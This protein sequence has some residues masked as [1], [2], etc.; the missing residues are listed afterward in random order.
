MDEV[1]KQLKHTIMRLCGKIPL[2]EKQDTVGHS[3]CLCLAA[4][5]VDPRFRRLE[6]TDESHTNRWVKNWKQ[7]NEQANMTDSVLCSVAAP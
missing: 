1:I 2:C 6:G 4:G 5:E 7:D 3:I